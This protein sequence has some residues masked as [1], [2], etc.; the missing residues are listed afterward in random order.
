[1]TIRWIYQGEAG[2]W[3]SVEQ[4]FD[5]F[6]GGWRGGVTPDYYELHDMVTKSV[7]K[8]DTVSEAKQAALD[9]LQ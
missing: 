8:Y 7:I 5:I 2:Y 1:M 4:R 6:P 9:V 3:T